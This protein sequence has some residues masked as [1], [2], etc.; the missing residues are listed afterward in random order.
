MLPW[1]VRGAV[2]AGG[3]AD[4][5]ACHTALLYVGRV[6]VAAGETPASSCFLA[7]WTPRICNLRACCGCSGQ[8]CS[9]GSARG[10]LAREKGASAWQRR[11]TCAL[12]STLVASSSPLVA[13]VFRSFG[14]LAEVPVLAVRPEL[15]R[16]NGLGRLLLAALER[17]LAA[18]GVQVRPGLRGCCGACSFCGSTP[19]GGGEIHMAVPQQRA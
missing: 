17:L 11:S 18:V 5:S 16:R 12:T 4:Y 15:Q 7:A 14:W 13:A 19:R 8:D 3:R 2:M 9:R 1:L 10:V 6:A